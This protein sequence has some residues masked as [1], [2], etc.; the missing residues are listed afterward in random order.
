MSKFPHISIFPVFPALLTA[1]VL[2]LVLVSR[3]VGAQERVVLQLRWEHQFQFAGF[4]A[5]QWEGYF[6]EAGLEVEIRSAVKP[7]G[8]VMSAPKEVA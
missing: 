3:P 1:A 7:D 8:K 5:A 6:R 2:L 4:Y